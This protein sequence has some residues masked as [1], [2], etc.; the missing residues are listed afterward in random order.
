MCDIEPT[1]PYVKY[2]CIRTY[3]HTYKHIYAEAQV[4]GILL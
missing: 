4:N 2:A 3:I 1:Y